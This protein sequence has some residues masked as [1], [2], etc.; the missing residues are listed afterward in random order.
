MSN[1][2]ASTPNDALSRA[3]R[4]VFPIF[5]APAILLYLILF[6]LPSAI[7]VWITFNRWSGVG[8]MQFSGLRNYRL[9][10][11]DPI[12]QSSFI[13]TLLILFL[14]GGATFILSFVTMIILRQMA[15][16]RIVR[17]IIF[18]PNILSGVAVAILWGFL[19]QP[20]GLVNQGLA[21]FGITNHPAWLAESNLFAIIMLALLW[22]SIGFY[23]TIFLAAN[24]SIPPYY[25]EEAALAG[26]SAIQTFR[27]V[28]FPLIS[29]TV[30]IAAI[31]WSVGS[32]KVFELILAFAGGAGYL[33]S[34]KVW[35]T[36]LYSYAEAFAA[37]GEPRYGTSAASAFLTLAI[38][39]ILVVLINRLRRR[40]ALE[41]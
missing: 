37:T 22:L 33:P 26:A 10:I 12:F 19:F 40:E 17:A 20:D 29:D 15:A 31:I 16:R 14:V 11:A 35:N 39:G 13:N 27:H 23:T 3:R 34:T 38:A 18:F 21:V 2:Q 5:V 6:L 30:A 24:D 36:A 4:R 9:L 1:E 25:Y 41:L 28:T 7:T 32:I 8:P